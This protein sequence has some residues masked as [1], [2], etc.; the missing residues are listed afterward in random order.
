MQADLIFDPPG[1]SATLNQS[2]GW[3][4]G[5]R[6]AADRDP[7]RM[8]EYMGVPWLENA[9]DV[10]IGDD[11]PIDQ[12]E[13]NQRIVLPYRMIACKRGFTL[14]AARHQE[15]WSGR[16]LM[17]PQSKSEHTSTIRRMRSLSTCA[18]N[19]LIGDMTYKGTAEHAIT[20]AFVNSNFRLT[21]VL[22]SE[23]GDTTFDNGERA[24]VVDVQNSQCEV[25]NVWA[26]AQTG[27]TVGF[28]IKYV[29]VEEVVTFQPVSTQPAIHMPAFRA[30][31]PALTYPRNLVQIVPHVSRTG[32]VEP[33]DLNT[34]VHYVNGTK[35]VE[36]GLFVRLGLVAEDSRD[37]PFE[38]LLAMT[39]AVKRQNCPHIIVLVRV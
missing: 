38:P 29:E 8:R 11:T 30:L 15:L 23:K 39:S 12:F 24:V 37:E 36:P 32:V 2:G 25:S 13:S 6:A 21:G 34:E 1:R 18:L 20:P 3:D 31:Q 5:S 16:G 33:E 10:V 14:D 22:H 17:G 9:D 26:G 28:I 4:A 7:K 19:W 27:D 35:K